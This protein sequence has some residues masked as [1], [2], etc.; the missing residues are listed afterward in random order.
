MQQIIGWNFGLQRQVASRNIVKMSSFPCV[1]FQAH[2]FFA[3]VPEKIEMD[4][5]SFT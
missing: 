4:N 3:V 2:P 1:I 5:P